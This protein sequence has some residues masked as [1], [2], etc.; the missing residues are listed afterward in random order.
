[1]TSVLA[2]TFQFEVP[3]LSLNIKRA[4][5]G[6]TVLFWVLL[7]G[8]LLGIS[9]PIIRP[10][11]AFVFL[12]FLPGA[13]FLT[14]LGVEPRV[15][16]R[17][18][19]YVVGCSLLLLM[20]LGLAIHLL[21]TFLGISS[22]FSLMT[23][24][25]GVTALIV[26]LLFGLRESDIESLEFAFRPDLTVIFLLQLP[27]WAILSVKYLNVSGTNLP[28]LVTLGMVS[29][30]PVLVAIGLFPTRR[31]GLAVL[32]LAL[33]LLLHKSLWRMHVYRGHSSPITI[34]HTG[35]WDPATQNLLS[36]AVIPPMYAFLLDI[37]ILTELKVVHP[38]LVAFIPLGMYVMFR[39]YVGSIQGF[40]GASLF[41]FAHP[42]YFQ[43]P[44]EPRVGT[45]ILFLVLLGV[46]I[47]DT[48]LSQVKK[49]ILSLVFGIG[50]VVSHYGTSYYVMFAILGAGA[51]LYVFYPVLDAIGAYVVDPGPKRSIVRT[52]REKFSRPKIQSLHWSFGGFYLAS[53]ITWYLYT[54]KSRTFESL[55]LHIVNALES[56]LGDSSSLGSTATRLQTDY[57]GISIALSKYLYMIFGLLTVIGF[58][59]CYYRRFI[60]PRE[61][62]FDDDFL[63]LS[64]LLF[65]LFGGSLVFSG[66]WGG[67]R[68]MMIVFSFASIFIV[69]GAANVSRMVRQAV[70]R[71]T[72]V[73]NSDILSSFLPRSNIPF[74]AL[75]V[76]FLLLNTG[77]I[78]ATNPGGRAP[79]NVPLQEDF[80]ESEN[81]NL[82]RLLFIE[83]DTELHV[84]LAT[85]MNTDNEIYGDRLARA[86]ATDWY[87]GQ[88]FSKTGPLDVTYRFKKSNHLPN[89]DGGEVEQGYV[90]LLGHNI[91]YGTVAIDYISWTG[92][93]TFNFEFSERSRIYSNGQGMVY[94]HGNETRARQRL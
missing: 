64:S 79:S 14:W 5:I 89:I 65:V 34:W 74:G 78:A 56:L 19:V 42:F 63:A 60:N 71:V 46:V 9:I 23:F 84:W 49:G 31:L 8:Q 48:R 17:W 91:V 77:F 38:F 53:T 20:G 15:E 67:G 25:I 21:L 4:A 33:V 3:E 66:E 54:K 51:L 50:I 11:V 69:I 37:S 80:S 70:V 93:D 18:V 59:I 73:I 28:L 36:V 85:H 45:P 7:L 61:S 88:I 29:M 26:S 40:L 44:S 57:S 16:P 82:Q 92:I 27:L 75:L 47:S 68:P 41:I 52:L 83:T 24:S 39:T 6:L 86:Q 72:E 55:I 1:M 13:L 30:I 43:Y 10:V 12:T 22:P 2:R 76:I 62:K 35:L 94:Y 32:A 58:T 90:I 87:V 81:P